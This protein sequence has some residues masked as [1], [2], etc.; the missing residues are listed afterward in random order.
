MRPFSGLVKT[1][2]AATATPNK[3]YFV[4]PGPLIW[5]ASV[6]RSRHGETL[7]SIRKHIFVSGLEKHRSFVF[8]LFGPPPHMHSR[9]ADRSRSRVFNIELP[10]AK[11]HLIRC[12]SQDDSDIYQN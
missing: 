12:I 6:C 8:Q 10:V 11:S 9:E 4:A 7:T 1:L 5:K 3:L 2:L